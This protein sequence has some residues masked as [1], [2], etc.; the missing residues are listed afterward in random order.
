MLCAGG[1]SIQADPGAEVFQAAADVCGVK[2][3]ARNGHDYIVL[4]FEGEA[5]R[6]LVKEFGK[7]VA[8]RGAGY[9]ARVDEE[10]WLTDADGKKYAPA[11]AKSIKPPRQLAFEVPES[12]TGLVFHD[13]K[14]RSYPLSFGGEK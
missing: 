13:G 10:S 2:G 12:A 4:R 6:K 1:S 3:K 11:H 8:T 5:K 14:D 7:F 9:L